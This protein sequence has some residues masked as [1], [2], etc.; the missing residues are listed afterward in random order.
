MLSGCVVA[1]IAQPGATKD[2]APSRA[3]RAERCDLS[4]RW[5]LGTLPAFF[6]QDYGHDEL[7]VAPTCIA[8]GTTHAGDAA[9][10]AEVQHI[11]RKGACGAVI[12]VRRTE[13]L[14]IGIPEEADLLYTVVAKGRTLRGVWEAC[15]WNESDDTGGAPDMCNGEETTGTVEGRIE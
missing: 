10:V 11:V 12:S 8:Q 5:F 4:G 15:R 14:G 13:Y 9:C 1:P 7:A 3:D 2:P 6:V